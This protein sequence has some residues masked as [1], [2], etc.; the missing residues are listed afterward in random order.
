MQLLTTP[1]LP[2]CRNT[3]DNH[4]GVS[5]VAYPPNHISSVPPLTLCL[6]NRREQCI[7]CS[8]IRCRRICIRISLLGFSNRPSCR[9]KLLRMVL[10]Y[11]SM[12]LWQLPSI[13]QQAFHSFPLYITN[14]SF[15]RQ[16]YSAPHF[17][18]NARSLS[19]RIHQ[20]APYPSTMYPMHA[21]L[22]R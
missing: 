9:K 10:L 21:I 15:G 14:F 8:P 11:L 18:L 20:W 22:S 13:T 16:P 1:A 6:P 7:C 5:A 2:S 12:D 19:C 3:P 4:R 17:S